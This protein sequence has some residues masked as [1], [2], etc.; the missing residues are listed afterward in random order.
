MNEATLNY[1][2]QHADDDV[3]KL[4]LQGVK[5]TDV[6][7][8]QALQQIAGR[9]T[10]RRK[11]P[12]WAA[13]EGIVYPPHLNMEQCSSEQT[14]RYKAKIVNGKSVNGKSVNG[15]SVNGK[16]TDLTGGFG[17]DFYWMSQSFQQRYYIEQNEQLCAISS[18]NFHTLGLDCSVCCCDAVTYLTTMPH[19][20]LIYMDPA[21]RNEHGGRTYSIEDCTPNVIELL[22]LLMEKANRVMLKLS[23]MLDWRKAAD[24]LK[25]VREVHIVSVD[26]ECKELLI[27]VRKSEGEKVRIICVNLHSDGSEELFGF[28]NPSP[29]HSLTSSPSHLLTLSPPHPLTSSPPHFLY[30]PNASI[31]KAGCFKE[32]AERFSV[33][34]ISANSH[35]FLSPVEIDDF[36]GRGFQILSISSMN[37]QELRAALKDTDRANISVRNFPLT[38]DQLRKKLKLKDGGDV[39]IFATTTSDGAHRLHICRKIG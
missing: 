8:T 22:P 2:R 14:A 6:D 25:Y 38:P 30:E 7:L 26:N 20:D 10:A 32:L 36:P 34:Q 33:H 4:A 27:E 24:D 11:L 9:Q 12:S 29:S 23:P 1:A 37:K 39:Y 31:M 28:E 17:V 16:F 21:R 13:V 35:L 3:R 5:D 18:E 15:K 19:V